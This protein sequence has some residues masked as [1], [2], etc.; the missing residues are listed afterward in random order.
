MFQCCQQDVN[1]FVTSVTSTS[2]GVPRHGCTGTSGPGQAGA[3]SP[4][5]P[6]SPVPSWHRHGLS[7]GGSAVFRPRSG[8]TTAVAATAAGAAALVVAGTLFAPP[9]LAANEPVSVWL[10]TTSDSGGR[11]VTRGLQQQANIAFG[12]AGGSANQ[13]I[14]VNENTTYQ[15]FEGAGASI[16]DTTAYL[17]RG[18][19]ISAATR[20]AVMAK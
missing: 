17:L 18:G 19:P 14:T 2:L 8:W 20:D 10:T 15:Q 16:T 5:R 11:T 1:H 12:P 7:K 4:T 6:A 9:A 3:P 13:T